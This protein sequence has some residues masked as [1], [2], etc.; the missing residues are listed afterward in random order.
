[1]T[2]TIDQTA[3]DHR[4]LAD[5]EEDPGVVGWA[6]GEDAAAL[7]ERADDRPMPALRARS[8]SDLCI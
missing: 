7:P 4:H 6:S 5:I 8:Q 1:M 3:A 2:I